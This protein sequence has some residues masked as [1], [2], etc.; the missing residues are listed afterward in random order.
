MWSSV[1]KKFSLAISLFKNG[2]RQ[3]PQTFLEHDLQNNF[4]NLVLRGCTYPADLH[5]SQGIR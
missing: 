2:N 4:R 3:D 1:L 5:N